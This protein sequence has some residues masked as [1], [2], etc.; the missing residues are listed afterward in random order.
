MNHHYSIHYFQKK[1][2]REFDTPRFLK[3]LLPI[4]EKELILFA[5]GVLGY[6]NLKYSLSPS[7][8][9]IYKCWDP[10]S[11]FIFL[12]SFTTSYKWIG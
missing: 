10:F 12:S 9:Q 8:C 5:R 11:I 1:F 4:F 7:R 3:L 6:C 2:W